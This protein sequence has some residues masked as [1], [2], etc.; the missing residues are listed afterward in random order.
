VGI[1]NLIDDSAVVEATVKARAETISAI[2]IRIGTNRTD[3]SSVVTG[4]PRG[5]ITLN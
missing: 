1:R 5:V 2:G 3:S 4:I